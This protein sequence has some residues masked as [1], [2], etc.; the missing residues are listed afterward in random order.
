MFNFLNVEFLSK[1]CLLWE[2]IKL[3]LILQ[4]YDVLEEN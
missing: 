3:Y 1:I 4:H 2:L